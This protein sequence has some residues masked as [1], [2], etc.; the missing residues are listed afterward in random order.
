MENDI[1]LIEKL[2]KDLEY[3]NKNSCPQLVITDKEG[4]NIFEFQIGIRECGRD[5][6]I[7]SVFDTEDRYKNMNKNLTIGE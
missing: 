2:K 7:I 6:K 3:Y 1:N 5:S 4:N